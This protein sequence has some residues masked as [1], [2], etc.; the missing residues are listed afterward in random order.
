[1]GH[2]GHLV[3]DSDH[4]GQAQDALRR[5]AVEMPFRTAFQCEPVILGDGGKVTLSGTVP[6]LADR[7][8]ACQAAWKS[9]CATDVENNLVVA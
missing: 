5:R 3:L 9:A 2:G 1:M 8:V 4:A 7:Y 6:N